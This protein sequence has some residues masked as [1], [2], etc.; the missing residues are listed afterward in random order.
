MCAR[1]LRQSRPGTKSPRAALTLALL[2]ALAPAA[3]LR[4]RGPTVQV[5]P[6]PTPS[7]PAEPDAAARF[8]LDVVNHDRAAYGLPPVTWDPVAASA[9]QRHVDDLTSGGFTAHW[10][11]DGSVPEQRYTEAGGRH[12]AQ[13]NAACLADGVA[14]ALDPAPRIRLELARQLQ[15]A[16]MDEVPPHDGHRKNVLNPRHTRVGIALAQPRGVDQP[17]LVQEFVDDLGDFDPLPRTAAPGARVRVSGAVRGPWIVGG[18]GLLALDPARPMSVAELLATSSY[19]I[20]EPS[21]LHVPAGFV[22]P[23]P[24]VQVSGGRFDV[25]LT[26]PARAGRHEVSI[27][28]H[29]DHSSTLELI[30][31]RTIEVK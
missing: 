1:A 25:V 16:F 18:V 31:L 22:G 5:A 9:A 12:F 20:P 30:G 19:L 8:I 14:R 13:E 24:D 23:P 7:A 10:G 28:G 11:R 29:L 27:W 3:C 26:L 21:E 15:Q 6:L 17:C 4:Q 2:S